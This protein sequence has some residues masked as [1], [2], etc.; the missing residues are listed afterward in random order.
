MKKL[1]LLTFCMCFYCFNVNA[2]IGG[3]L[4]NAANKA[5]QKATEKA[6]DEATDKAV[7]AIDNELNSK[8]E[9]NAAKEEETKA[10]EKATVS[11]LMAKLPE[12]P[13]VQ[14]LVNYKSAE[15]N[16]QALKMMTSP[17]TSFN[18]KVMSLSMQVLSLPMEGADSAQVVENA[19]KQAEAAT[20]LSREEIDKLATMSEEEQEAYLKAHYTE[21]QAEA[22]FLQ[23]AAEAGKYLEPLQPMI[24]EWSAFDNKIEKIY[25]DVDAQCKTIYQKYAGKLEKASDA[26]RNS[27]LIKYYTEIAPLQRAAVQQVLNIRLNEQLPVAEKIETEMVK[28]RAEHQDLISVMLNYPQMT[29][30][31]YFTEVLR[32][33]DIPEFK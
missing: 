27:Q 17:V 32:L 31:Q 10:E 33:T 26:E 18:A 19:Y 12:L 15:L 14:Q 1:L 4:R 25:K 9:Q 20:G 24:D 11:S 30:T 5:A 7:E 22:A 29:A 23:Q 8:K 13:T 28:I 21:G 6:V 3:I 2:Q 16:E